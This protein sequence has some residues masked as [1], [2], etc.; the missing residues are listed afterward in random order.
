MKIPRFRRVVLPV[1][2]FIAVVAIH[3]IWLGLFP[4]QDPAQDRWVTVGVSRDNPWLQHYA[5]TQSYWLGFSYALSIAFAAVAL[6]RHRETRLCKPRNLAVG[7]VS[8]SGLLAVAGCYVIGCCGSPM[9]AVYLG[10]LGATYLPWAKPFVAL[11]T[12]L[13][14]SVAWWWMTRPHQSWN[15][16]DPGAEASTRSFSR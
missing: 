11:L 4:Q 8:L 9:L 2:T 1:S 16:A 10:L 12:V 5:E 14:I 7:G 6:R 13:L 3:Y 15:E